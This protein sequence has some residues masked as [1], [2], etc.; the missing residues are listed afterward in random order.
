MN[1]REVLLSVT[2]AC[3]AGF[4]LGL[5][6]CQPADASDTGQRQPIAEDAPLPPTE[7][8]NPYIVVNPPDL[9][10]DASNIN[11]VTVNLT[12]GDVCG[13]WQSKPTFQ[14]HDYRPSIAPSKPL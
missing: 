12:I 7:G 4:A 5:V 11:G 10:P 8:C 2:T 13:H 1:N 3:V 6:V 9:P 14:P